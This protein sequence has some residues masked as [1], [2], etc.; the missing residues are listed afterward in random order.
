M[1]QS[2]VKY[3]KTLKRNT[4]DIIGVPEGEMRENGAEKLITKIMSENILIL[5]R[6]LVIQIYE[7]H[8]S[9]KISTQKI[10]SLEG[11]NK[12]L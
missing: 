6:D 8:R 1:K 3:G 7:A 9:P 11:Y 2:Y 12:T 10:F 5:G 4:L